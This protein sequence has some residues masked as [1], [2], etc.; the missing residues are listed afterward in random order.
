MVQKM[1]RDTVLSIVFILIAS[2]NIGFAQ[3]NF[4]NSEI[5]QYRKN[6]INWGLHYAASPE[7]EETRTEF[8]SEYEELFTGAAK[9]QFNK[10]YWD[11]QEFKQERFDFNLGAGLLWGNG[12]WVDSSAVANIE[13][14]HK[15]NGLR[16]GASANYTSRFYYN[17]RN[18]TLVKV[19]GWARYDLYRQ[20]S[21]GVSTDSDNVVTIL[22]EQTKDNKFRYGAEGR[23]G[24]GMG[25]LKPMNHF[26]AADYILKTYYKHRQFSQDEIAKFAAEIGRI[27]HRRNLQTTHKTD[28]EAGQMQEFLNQKMFLIPVGSLEHE[29]KSGEFLPRFDGNRVEFGPFFTYYNHEPDFIYGGYFM[30]NHFKYCSTNW[31]RN[32]SI[33]LNY[34]AYK[35]QD[36]ILAEVD[37]GWSYFVKIRGQFDFGVKYIPG[38]AIDGSGNSGELNNGFIPYLGYFTQIDSKN[39]IDVKLAYRISED[40]R[41]MLSGPEVSVSVYRSRY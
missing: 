8:W 40:E 15:I 27:K 10:F 22:N 24:W 1:K 29:W 13:A 39:R 6:E 41:L 31:N 3:F 11:F 5:F 35:R 33:G 17:K 4:K 34:N 19:S 18:Y 16:T 9:F 21:T 26:M 7:M 14:D 2:S 38:I 36:W 37:M 20:N 25:R 32:F 30:F 23:A 28:A 12:N